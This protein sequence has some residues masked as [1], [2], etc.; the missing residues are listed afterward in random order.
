MGLYPVKRLKVGLRPTL[1][2]P[3]GNFWPRVG[4]LA[5]KLFTVLHFKFLSHVTN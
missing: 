4:L 1:L 5:S 3:V 2:G